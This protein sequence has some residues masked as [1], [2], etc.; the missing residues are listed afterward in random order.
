M[1]EGLLSIA[2]PFKTKPQCYKKKKL[3][4]ETHQTLHRH[5]RRISVRVSSTGCGHPRGILAAV[6]NI[7]PSPVLQI[8]HTNLTTHGPPTLLCHFAFFLLQPP[9]RH[10]T[11]RLRLVR[12]KLEFA[13]I[14][15]C[16]HFPLYVPGC[17]LRIILGHLNK[18]L[19][20]YTQEWFQ[21]SLVFIWVLAV[22]PQ[23][24]AGLISRL[25]MGLA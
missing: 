8:L 17:S 13:P 14:P 18:R 21:T 15:A 4:K 19:P 9:H 20:R 16:P 6:L 12:E 1:A 5:F 22:W 23:T 3:Q 11:A 2:L 25:M 24:T 7:S 10:T